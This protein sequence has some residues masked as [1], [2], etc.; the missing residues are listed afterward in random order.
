MASERTKTPLGWKAV[1]LLGSATM[2]LGVLWGVR[3][4]NADALAPSHPAVA[5]CLFG[6]VAVS[7]R[8]FGN[9]LRNG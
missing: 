5:C 7:L 6:V 3:A 8:T 1:E 4:F 2:L 9:W